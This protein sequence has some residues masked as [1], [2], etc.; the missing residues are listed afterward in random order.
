MLNLLT[1]YVRRFDEEF[2]Y[3]V[4]GWERKAVMTR[5]T[6]A[7]YFSVRTSSTVIF[8]LL[9]YRLGPGKVKA[10]L[11]KG[12]GGTEVWTKEIDRHGNMTM[13]GKDAKTGS[14]CK[15]VY[16]VKLIVARL[17]FNN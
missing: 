2:D 1:D 9:H 14:E 4:P 15:C 6:S 11:K 12:D 3:T 13:H 17:F 10:I 8:Y 5:Y 16:D 7:T